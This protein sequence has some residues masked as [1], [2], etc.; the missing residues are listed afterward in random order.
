LGL[1]VEARHRRQHHRA[2]VRKA[3]HVFELD[4]A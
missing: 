4:T 3:L 2:G 1:M